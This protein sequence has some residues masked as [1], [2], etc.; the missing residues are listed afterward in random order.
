[1]EIRYSPRFARRYKKL[2]ASVQSAAE[3]RE[4]IFRKDWKNPLLTAHKLGGKLDGLWAFSVNNRYRIIFEFVATHT[5]I[6]HT[7]GDHGI[8]ENS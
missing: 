3:R 6:F 5:V 1:M 8:Y 7:I 2:L 4:L